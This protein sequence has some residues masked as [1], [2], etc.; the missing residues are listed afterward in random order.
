ME[1]IHAY[2]MFS[3]IKG[4]SKLNEEQLEIFASKVWAN[5]LKTFDGLSSKINVFNTWGDA[6]FMIFK[7]SDVLNAVIRYRDYFRDVEFNRLGLPH[8]SVRIGCHF[9]DFY[10]FD[11]PVTKCSNVIGGNINTTARIEPVTRPNDIFVTQSFVDRFNED[12][13][14]SKPDDIEFDEIGDIPLAKD[15]GRYN[16]YL[17]RTEK[18][19]EH[20][21]DRLVRQDL[22]KALPDVN[23]K[24]M[25]QEDKL[26]N[27]QSLTAEDFKKMTKNILDENVTAENSE[28]LLE[29]ARLHKDNGF[30]DEAIKI[31]EKLENYSID[32]D[33]IKVFPYKR[34]MKLDKIKANSLT[35]LGRYQEAGEIMYS[36]WKSGTQDSDTL[37]MLAAQYKRR[38]FYDE[39]NNLK[40]EF[41]SDLLIRSRDLYLEAF[42]RNI[43]DYYPAIN[44]AYLSVILRG[45]DKGK[46]QD[47]ANYIKAVWKKDF[48]SN[49]WI[50]STIAEACLICSNFED[51]I[52]YFEKALEK[53]KP[54]VFNVD[55]TIQQIELFK[56]F[57]QEDEI[58]DIITV[59]N[60]YRQS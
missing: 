12:K 38:A 23:E 16:I 2:I 43:N 50:S 42:R 29:I 37:S 5:S 36:L 59:L 46:G 13:L 27:Y 48:G 9:G 11:D 54:N 41:N 3:D 33:G 57:H 31:A 19:E 47:L 55:S 4:F 30:Y 49:W 60:D 25:A 45:S 20:I 7:A 26:E 35:R 39:N 6:I 40:A 22:I 52:A 14:H 17:L 15:F 44:T 1:R 51:A 24:T 18:E 10:I 34:N 53:C 28:Y 56:H 8:L 21:L 58:D 32:A